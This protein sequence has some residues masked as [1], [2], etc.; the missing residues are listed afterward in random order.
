MSSRAPLN[1]PENAVSPDDTLTAFARMLD[2]AAPGRFVL[3]FVK[4]NLPAQRQTLVEK[5][6][7]LV[8]PLGV[9][10]LEVELT[11]PT[12]RLLPILRE[13]LTGSY[14]APATQTQDAE[15]IPALREGKGKVA[16]FVYGLEHSLPSGESNHPILSHLN[17]SRELFRRDVPC[18]LVIWLPD[19]ALTLLAR[20]AP[21]FWAWRS[22]VYEFPPEPETAQR[23]A[24]LAVY[25]E[26]GHVTSNLS[27][28]AKRER[29]R[30][31]ARLLD[32]YREL[33][34]NPR[35]RSTQADILWKMGD[36]YK[37]LGEWNEARARYQEALELAQALDEPASVA[38]LLHQLAMLAQDTGDLA[39][40][41]RLYEQSL[42]LKR[43]LGDKQGIA[44]TLH[45]LGVLAQVTGD[46]AEARRL[47]EQSLALERELGN[48][49]GIAQSLHQLG[50]LAQ[51]TGDLAEARR[52]YEQS[53]A[54][55]H[56]LGNKQ[57]IAISLHQ[58]GILAQEAGDLAEARRLYEQ[59]LAL[60]RELGD[61]DGEAKT[62]NVLANISSAEGDQET[63]R[64]LL[65]QS[66][67]IA[68]QLGDKMQVAYA[69]W[70][71]SEVEEK[72]GNLP[73]ALSLIQ[74]AEQLFTE[75]GSPMREQAKR[76]RERLEGKGNE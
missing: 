16:L 22:G 71:L 49:Q 1:A 35:E 69:S 30:L 9:T 17:L 66:L 2:F 14:L 19:Y 68:K 13:R 33:G 56:E 63:A 55:E 70:G 6:K 58:L 64:G 54:F 12:E 21:D 72:E 26:A 65:N 36:V 8:E 48:K 52:L 32:D 38:G 24:R 59:S 41:R 18:P 40:A 74:Q 43:E 11:E 47:Y 45:Q 53:L 62:L 57:G 3:A 73:A 10:L 39:E 23:V 51:A 27:E 61:K 60:A 28:S 29:L 5:I 75:L 67:L 7:V 50:V 42:A 4:C 20:G 76:V 15:R 34:D 44:S 31:L 46:L 37:D 25:E